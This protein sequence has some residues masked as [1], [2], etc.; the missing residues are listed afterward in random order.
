MEVYAIFLNEP[1]ETCWDAIQKNWPENHFI[2]TKNL[3]FIV[4]SDNITTKQI[5]DK[6]GIYGSDKKIVGL[7]AA[8]KNNGIGVMGKKLRQ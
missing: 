5:A 7:G 1:N 2:L 3:A 8:C 6:V 4:T